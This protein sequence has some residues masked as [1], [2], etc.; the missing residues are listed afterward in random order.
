MG[1]DWG[2]FLVPAAVLL[3]IP[4]AIIPAYRRVNGSIMVSGALAALAFAAFWLAFGGLRG[5]A[6]NSPA[7]G[8]ALYCGVV[9]TLATWA[10]TINAAAQAR[11]WVWVALLVVAGYVTAAAIY[12]SFSLQTC[13][14]P[15]FACPPVD[16]VRQ[17]LAFAGYLACPVA[18]LVYGAV[19][20]AFPSLRRTRKPPAGLT[21]SPLWA[22]GTSDDAATNEM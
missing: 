9:L 15:E 7:G 3:V 17:A 4:I 12:A 18:A 1:I 16:P 14:G 8:I 11:R 6:G 13:F 21:V 20:G 2:V 5:V 10:L 22:P 19:P